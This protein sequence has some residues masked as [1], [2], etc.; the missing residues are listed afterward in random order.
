M[1]PAG[2]RGLP[3]VTRTLGEL[4]SARVHAIGASVQGAAIHA[5]SFGPAHARDVSIVIGGLHAIE[6]IGVE[7]AL[8]I[9]A[10]I[11]REPPRDRVVHVIALANPDG[12]HAIERDLWRGRRRFRR[13]NAN[14]V[15]LNRNWATG[16]WP[17]RKWMS[18]FNWGGL[19]ACS[20]PEV[21]AIVG[22]CDREVAR[23][24]RVETAL[25]LHSFGRKL[26]VPYG[27]RWRRPARYRELH[28]RARG[29]QSRLVERYTI[30]QVSRWLPGAFVY[31]MEID[32]LHDRYGACALLVECAFGGFSPFDPATWLAPFHWYNPR[33]PSRVVAELA[34]ALE[35]F[36]RGG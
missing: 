3:D 28:E 15:D 34:L 24:A 17:R 22:L 1:L 25:S 2:Y 20:E 14:G 12:Y 19:A 18:G 26:L 29:V 9:A 31:G 8:A 10:R 21:A 6:W 36:V 5:A 35:P 7:T 13:T 4:R 16:F 11:D 33:R 27:G 32:D 23:G 30:D